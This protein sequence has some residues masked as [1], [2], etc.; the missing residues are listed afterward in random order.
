[1]LRTVYLT[2]LTLA[3]SINSFSQDIN[4]FTNSQEII[5]FQKLY[6]HTDREF[7]FIGDTL[8]F[9]AHQLDAKTHIP[10]KD[11]CNLY[12][13]LV[14]ASGELIQKELFPITN[15]FCPGYLSLNSEETIEGNYLIRTYTDYLKNFGDEYFFTKTIK[16]S[17]VKSSFQKEVSTID[18][19]GTIN[20]QLYPEGGFLLA[21]KINQIAFV[22]SGMNGKEVEIEGTIINSKKEVVSEF[23]SGYKGR[24]RFYF[25]P[26]HNEQYSID[27]KDSKIINYTFPEIVLNGAKLML[28]RQN[29]SGVTLHI[30]TNN[31]IQDECF[32]VVTLHRGV[33]TYCIT[34]KD[35]QILS[36]IKIQPNLLNH[37]INRFVLLNNNFEPI[38]ERLVFVK[39]D[40]STMK[41]E[42][43]KN[44]FS[45]R[46]LV[47]V[48]FKS[49]L[50][51]PKKDFKHVSI[52]VVNENAINA[53]GVS[54]NINSYLLV[55]SELRGQIK[56]PAN[57]FIDEE[58]VSSQEKLDLLML[59]NGWSHYIWNSLLDFN[60]S[61][62][63]T[64][65]YGASVAGIIS[66]E[67]QTKPL[68]NAEVMLSVV[69]N[70]VQH[71]DFARSGISGEFS[72][73][74][75]SFTD[76][77]LVLIQAKN[78]KNKTKT[79]LTLATTH[80][81]SPQIP[82]QGYSNLNTF[83]DIPVSIFRTN[84]LN[85]LKLNEFYPD[86]N[87]RL[88]ADIDIVAKKK[89]ELLEAKRKRIINPLRSL[90]I[91][92]ENYIYSNV[93]EFLKGRVAGA[94][95]VRTRNGRYAVIIRGGATISGSRNAEYILNGMIVPESSLTET[96][97]SEIK[98]VEVLKGI[99]ASFLGIYGGRG[100]VSVTTK[101]AEDD[102][103]A[104]PDYIR[105]TIVQKI[106]GFA[107]YREFYS[108]IYSAE[109]IESEA[110]DF[111]TTL[112][113]NPSVKMEN[114][115]AN[116]IFYSCDN[117]ARYK[118]FVEGITQTGNIVMG[119][120]NFEVNQRLETKS[121]KEKILP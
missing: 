44:E 98:S 107:S 75:L 91:K 95:V 27:I 61:P 72:F 99:E 45:T 68:Q 12:I 38:S 81:S 102:I 14:N 11:S 49:P 121:L 116:V 114:G 35:Q 88:L 25:K 47:Q 78:N 54:Q 103:H 70:E 52:S 17:K 4:S 117:I 79:T 85:E 10:L 112:Y 36:S 86:R 92:P 28:A 30:L 41:L 50:G 113:W 63:A 59:T 42:L 66:K 64:K 32:H 80:F 105:G 31:T 26:Q 67:F 23:R 22:A 3:V 115:K 40:E 57:Y 93:F 18:S 33:A 83:I 2:L 94:Q 21:D 8:W 90:T 108:P 48:K 109:N 62:I 84:Y 71:I 74:N 97:M 60:K 7:Y 13:E 39:K 29:E 73:D 5:P 119:E 43:E 69:K 19:S 76:S 6:L 110:P 34:L 106:K 24:G 111:R 82:E 100:A 104:A 1:M 89:Q 37:G 77:A 118:I 58:K 15:G 101:T 53:S 56:S 65:R 20:I 87:S 9:A 120:S 16:I 96:P 46:D 55:D 51:Y